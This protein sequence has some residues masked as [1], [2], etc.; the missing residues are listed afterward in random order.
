MRV[1]RSTE[2]SEVSARFIPRTGAMVEN[3]CEVA[4]IQNWRKEN[5]KVPGGIS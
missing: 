5:W 1:V 3:L 4:L 2:D